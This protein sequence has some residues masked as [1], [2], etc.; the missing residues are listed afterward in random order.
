MQDKM[1]TDMEERLS[2]RRKWDRELRETVQEW[3]VKLKEYERARHD[4]MKRKW[5]DM[6]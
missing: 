5:R 6:L 1:K 2:R 4:A 3:E